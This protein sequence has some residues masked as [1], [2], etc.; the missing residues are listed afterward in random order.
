MIC[1]NQVSKTFKVP[2]RDSG[3]RSAIRSFF[4][5]EYKEINAVNNLSY[6]I[7]DGEI[8]GFLGPNG[9]GKSTAIK[10]MCGILSNDSGEIRINGYNPF[11]DRSEYVANIGVV[12]G[13]RSQLWWDIPVVDS[14]ALLKDIY[15]VNDLEYDER[16]SELVELL[17]L[18]EIMY[19]PTRQLSLGQKMRCEIAASL[20]HNPSVLFLDEPTIG[21]DA[22]TK[23]IVRKMIHDINQKYGTTIIL[24][25][26]DMQ[27]IESLVNRLLIIDKG[28]LLFD[29]NIDQ[30]KDTYS[31]GKIIKLNYSGQLS[32]SS[33][34]EIVEHSDGYAK[35]YSKQTMSVLLPYLQASIEINDLSVEDESIENT[36]LHCFGEV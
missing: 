19:Q 6:S 24:T 16:L 31:V 29:G 17:N 15:K 20:L 35:L 7:K 25:T 1:F 32:N 13:Q 8:V 28:K 18:K 12:F 27:D 21:L 34:Y 5:R 33:L 3:T 9:A 22:A 2:V 36:L 11:E 4:H 14:F 23:R 10:M 26:H 30:F